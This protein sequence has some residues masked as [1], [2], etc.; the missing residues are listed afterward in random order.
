M[1]LKEEIRN[2]IKEDLN[3]VQSKLKVSKTRGYQLLQS[4]QE[5][6]MLETDHDMPE[7][8]RNFYLLKKGTQEQK[9]AVCYQQA[10]NLLLR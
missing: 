10:N 5:I 2:L 6:R 3:Y 8:Q 4:E 7:S 1:Q 9:I